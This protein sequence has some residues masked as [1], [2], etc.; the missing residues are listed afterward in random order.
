MFHVT[1]TILESL[2]RA[3]ESFKTTG[4][5]MLQTGRNMLQTY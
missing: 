2:S 3:V 1:Q 4:S 5:G